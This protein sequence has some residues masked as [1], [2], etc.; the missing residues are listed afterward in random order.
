MRLSGVIRDPRAL[1]IAV[2]EQRRLR[3]L[4]Q[5]EAAAILGVSQR[6]LGEIE[7]GKPK[8]L[9]DRLFRVLAQLGLRLSIE[10]IVDIPL[11][12]PANGDG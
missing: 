4:S 11:E 5:R 2:A 8:I 1:G 3:R 9:D 10:S 12:S 7:L 6:Y